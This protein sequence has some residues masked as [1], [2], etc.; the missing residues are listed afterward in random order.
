MNE[1]NITAEEYKKG[2]EEGRVFLTCSNNR[3]TYYQVYIIENNKPKSIYV[4][5]SGYWN[6]KKGCYYCN[7][8]GTSRSLEVILSIGRSLNL[9]FREIRQNYQVL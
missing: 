3:E 1:S 7:A 9:P 2:L 4:P 6:E 5:G 8:M